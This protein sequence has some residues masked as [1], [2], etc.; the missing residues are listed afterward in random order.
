MDVTEP[1][2][3]RVTR[4]L[5]VRRA[6]VWSAAVSILV[7]CG[8]DLTEPLPP[9]P[10][11]QVNVSPTHLA[12]TVDE[13]VQLEAVT[14][15]AEGRFVWRGLAWS[16]ADTNVATVDTAGLVTGIAVGSTEIT[17][18]SEGRSDSATIV[19]SE[20]GGFVQI[21]LWDLHT[22]GIATD[23]RTYCWGRPSAGRLGIGPLGATQEHPQP[24]PAPVQGNREFVL[25]TAGVLHSCALNEF[26]TPSCW[27]SNI[28]GNLG[29]GDEEGLDRNVPGSVSVGPLSSL[30]SGY[31]HNC[32]LRSADGGAEC[33]GSNYHGQVG[34]GGEPSEVRTPVSVSGDLT[35]SSLAAGGV[36]TCGADEQ[37]TAHC[38]GWNGYGQ[39][40]IGDTEGL[41]DERLTPQ[42]VI[43]GLS[44]VS[45]ALGDYHSCGVR[46]DG[47]A[48]CWGGDGFGQ[49][50]SGGTTPDLCRDAQG[51]ESPCSLSPQE[52]S[53]GLSFERL[54]G[55]G[56]HTCGIVEGGAVYCWG[57]NDRGQLGIGVRSEPVLE[58]RRIVSELTFASL[59]A[60]FGHTCGITTEDTA[61]C[62]GQNNYGQLGDGT[63]VDRPIP[64]RVL[65]QN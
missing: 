4:I 1:A 22:C 53:G 47:T 38:W 2:P 59:A 49:L 25:V 64:V 32:G 16:S 58:P 50:G 65:G 26:G 6:L 14:V 39:L 5:E 10:V 34:N 46:A 3:G 11:T 52:V 20:P 31:H 19:V 15:D 36:H 44:F 41:D 40:G 21:A 12:I 28:F 54:A 29:N 33:W 55:G 8:E 61:Y 45:L 57:L 42:E 23:R 43:G 63:L 17:V 9:V 24:S 27:G 56:W 37:G 60:G 62:W 48:Y 13:R 7:G 35:F 18:T 51:G 30:V